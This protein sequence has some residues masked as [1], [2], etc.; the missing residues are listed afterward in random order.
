VLY[1]SS[2]NFFCRYSG[3]AVFPIIADRSI[4]DRSAID[5]FPSIEGQK[6]IR[7]A[8]Q[9]HQSFALRAFHDYSLPH[10]ESELALGE[11]NLRSKVANVALSIT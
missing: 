2:F 9:H 5:T 1:G 8:F 10:C 4:D 11:S 3:E 7:E 6:E